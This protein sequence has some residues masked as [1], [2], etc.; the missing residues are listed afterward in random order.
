MINS[1]IKIRNLL[2]NQI[3]AFLR[4]DNP[5]FL[6]FLSEYFK[7]TE[8]QGGP[9]D[10]LNNIDQYVKLDNISE[11][12][13]NTT[14]SNSI[15]IF[16]NEVVV[17]STEG[18]PNNYGLIQ[19]NN[20][21]I[22]YGEKT[23][24]TFLN[25][26]RGFSGITSY[27]GL[28]SDS[29]IFSET[30]S[31]EHSVG[32][33]V[34]NLGN[35]FLRELYKKFKS[36]YAP[37]FD[38]INLYGDVNEKILVSKLKDFYASKGSSP[39][40]KILFKALYGQE[41]DII[42]P[43]D[44]VIQASDADYRITRDLV[45]EAISG[46]PQNLVNL[47]LFQDQTDYINEASG[48][49]TK[50]EKIYRNDIEYYQIS[51]DY[52]P[53]LE[54]SRFT[55][56]PKTKLISKSSDGDT[57]FLVD[58][59]LGFPSYGTLVCTISGTEYY[60]DYTSKSS[61]Q[62]FGCSD[63]FDL[64]VGSYLTTK[65]F[66]YANG[67]DGLVKIR[68]TGVLTELDYPEDAHSYSVDDQIDI[69]SMG[70]D[71]IGAKY[72]NWIFNITPSYE[73]VSLFQLTNKIN[74][75]ARFRA[76][77]RDQNIF[78]LGDIGVLKSNSG[79]EYDF[80]VISISDLNNFD[81]NLTSD[82]DLNAKYT[83][84]RGVTLTNCINYP[85]VNINSTDVQ[86]VYVDKSN[87]NSSQIADD[88]YVVS[89]SLPN[90]LNTPLDIEDFSFIFSGEFDGE[91]LNVGENPF[92]SGD[93]VYYESGGS[94][95]SLNIPDGL[96]FIK[97]E[98]ANI[99]KLATS[100][101]NIT[102]SS[103]ISVFGDVTNNKFQLFKFYNKSLKS[104]DLIRK[105]QSPINSKE[106][107]ETKPGSVGILVNGVELLNYKSND[108]IFYGKINNI[109]I[110]SPG[111]DYDVINPPYL[112]IEDPIGY[113][114]TGVVHVKGSLSKIELINKGFDYIDEP[115]VSIF[116]GN[117]TGAKAK[118]N[119]SA[120]SQTIN[121]SSGEEYTQ[122]NLTNN[123]IGF[124]TYHKFREYEKVIYLTFGQTAIGGLVDKSVYYTEI[125][126]GN[127][128]KLYNNFENA[129]AGINT[130]NFT[131]YGEGS[132]QFKS[133]NKKQIISSIEVLSSGEGY[134]NKKLFFDPKNVNIYS[135]SLNIEN[136]QYQDKEIVI[137]TSSSSLIS[138][139]SS[140]SQYYVKV[141]DKNNIR[142]SSVGIGTT[143]SQDYFYNNKE[144]VSF[145]DQGT[146][147]HELNYLPIVVKVE[148][149]IGITTLSGQDFSAKFQ[150]IFTGNISGVSLSNKG[151]EY[152]NDDIVNYNREP[153]VTLIN[154]SDA[155]V[156]P[157][158]SSTGS[159]I[160]VVINSSGKYYNSP[161]EFTIYGD[162]S[163]CILTGIVSN[164]YLVD[165]K[166]VSGGSGYI[167]NNTR[168][169]VTSRGS[170]VKFNTNITP[171]TINLVERLFDIS[172]ISLD[173]GILTNSINPNYELQ[174]CH[175]YAPRQLRQ[176]LLSYSLGIDGTP[177][178]RPDLE[179]DDLP[180]KYH[181]PIIGWAYDGN[182]I[183]GPY[184]Y[185]NGEGGTVRRMVSGYIIRLNPERP[186]NYNSGIFIEDYVFVG[187]GDLDVHNGRT[188]KTPEFPNGTYAYFM[189]LQGNK[190]STGIF[191]GLLKP[192]FPYIIGQSYKSK[193][194]DFNYDQN[195]NQKTIDLNSTGWLRNT[196][197]YG[198]LSKYTYYDGVVQ[199]N[200]L[201]QKYTLVSEI[202][203]GSVDILDIVSK[204]INYSVNDRLSF[205]NTD[206]S[207]SGAYARITEIFG[208][209]VSEIN[210]VSR[211]IPNVQ[212]FPY[213]S[214]NRFI[215]FSSS[216]HE[217]SNKDIISIQNLNILG[218]RFNSNF[219]VEIPTNILKLSNNIPNVSV[220]GIVTYF[221]VFGNI[222]YPALT[223]NDTLGIGTEQVKVLEIDYNLSKIKV[224]REENFTLG[225]AHSQGA[226]IT[227]IPRKFYFN[228]SG[229]TTSIQYNLNTEIY[230]NPKDTL[231]I[232]SV[233]I[234]TTIVFSNPGVGLTEIFVPY[235]S[236]YLPTHNLI[237]GDQLVYKNNANNSIRVST[238]TSSY[239]LPNN[240]IVYVGKISN[241]LIGISTVKIGIGTTGGFIGITTSNAE[242]LTFSNFGT[243]TDHS[244][245][246]NFDNVIVGDVYKKSADVTT[247]E[248]HGLIVGD[249][250]S[251]NV[252]SG[253][254]T[255]LKVQYNDLNRRLVLDPRTF[256]S[257]D[258]NIVDNTIKISNHGYSSGQKL[259]HVS[260]SPCGGLINGEIYYAIVIDDNTIKLSKVYYNTINS[261]SNL[262]IINIT[263]ASIGTLSQV[264]PRISGI[265][266]STII[267]DLSDPSLSS[268]GYPAFDFNLYT[269][270]NFSNKFYGT[271]KDGSSFNVTKTG[272]IGISNDA[273]LTLILD[274]NTPNLYY[275]LE[276]VQTDDVALSKKELIV[277]DFNIFNNNILDIKDSVYSIKSIVTGVTTNTFSYPLTETPEKS[278]YDDTESIIYYNTNSKTA[279]GPAGKI[280][281][282]SGGRYYNNL[283]SIS[284]VD[285]VGIGSGG[286]FLP[287]SNSIGRI[288][289]Y[290]ISDIGFDYPCDLSLRPSA[291]LPKTFKI[292]PL[293][294][295]ESIRIISP[296]VNYFVAPQLVVID[297]FTGRVNNEVDLRYDIGDTEVTVVRNTTGLYNINPT[298]IPVNNPNGI[299]I[300]SIEYTEA[301]NTVVVGLAITFSSLESFPFSVGDEFI[302]ENTNILPTSELLSDYGYNSSSYNY[303][304]FVAT[305][306]NPDIGG[307]SPT[308]TFNLN[309]Y[310]PPG[311]S[312]G[313]FDSFES[314]GTVTPKNYFPVFLVTLDKGTFI[315]GETVLVDE[316][317][318]GIVQSYDSRNEYLKIR[319]RNKINVND[320]IIGKTSGNKG[321]ISK[322]TEYD[323]TYI[324]GSNSITR[325]GWEKT[326]GY[327]SDN[328]QRIHDNDYYQY[329]SYSVRSPI[330]Y[331]TW[332]PLVSTLNH[333]SGFKKFGELLI[334][335]YDPNTVGLSTDQ[336]LGFNSSIADIISEV[337]LNSVKDFDIAKE[338]SIFVDDSYVSNEL[339]FRLPFLQQYQEFIG[340]R[341]LKVDDISSQFN[342]DNRSFDLY[343]N[344][345][346]IF[347]VSFYGNNGS[348]VN[349]ND[350][351]VDLTNHYFVSG[352]EIQYVPP[353]NDFSNAIG[354][355]L[356]TISGI[357]LTDK[358]PPSV[359][360]IKLDNQKIQLASTPQNSLLFNPIPLDLT[361]VGIGSTHTFKSK[362]QNTRLLISLNGMIQSPVVSTGIT[363]KLSSLVGIGSTTIT[364]SGISSIFGGDLLQIDNEIMKVSGVGVGSTNSI[365]VLR[366]WMGTS[367]ASHI[368]NTLITKLNGNYN[369]V[370]NT[371]SFVEPIWGNEPVG[372]G[373]TAISQN[374]ID[375]AGLTTSTRFSGRVFL[376]SSLNQAFTTSYVKAY[377][378]NYIFDDISQSFNG[379][380]T[381][382]T[383]KQ[384]KIGITSIYQ[385]NAIILVSDIFQGPQRLG[386][387]LTD[388]L[389]D[390]KLTE[391]SGNT[392]LSFTG[393]TPNF[394]IT[395][396]INSTNV[397][398]GG[399]IVSVGS[400]GGL[401]YQ[402][403]VGGGGT[404]IVSAAGTIQS[405]SIGNSGSGY[406]VG[407]QTYIKVG[408]QTF[409]YGIPKITYVG[410]ASAVDG[411][412]TSVNIT[413]PGSGYTSTNPPSVVI[414]YPLSYTD[415]PL[416]YSS[417][418]GSTG[419]GTGATVDIIV[420]Q[421]SSVINFELKNTGYGYGQGDILTV[422]IGGTVGIPTD[423]STFTLYPY[424]EFNVFVDKIYNSKF[425]GWSVGDLLVMDDISKYFNGSRKLFPLSIN[426]DR[427]SFFAK[428]SSGIDLQSNL[429]VFI[430]DVLQIPG[431][432]YTFTGGSILRF[433]DAPRGGSIGIS[434]L[435]DTCK[436]LM[437]TGTQT[438][439][440]KTVSVLETIKIGDDVQLYSDL[441]QT[442]NEDQRL[443]VDVKSA[444]S[445][446]TNNYAGQGV[447]GD[448]LLERPI[449]W[450]RQL[451]DKIIDEK[452]VGKDR[453]Y[454]EPSI[455]PSSYLLSSVGIGSTYIFVNSIRPFF[456][457][458]LEGISNSERNSITIISQ[459]NLI[460]AAAT[461]TISGL[462]TISTI[463]LTN[464]GLGYT[465]APQITIQA[466]QL[467]SNQSATGISSI[468]SVGIVTSIRVGSGGTG[469]FYGPLETLTITQQGSYFP[470]IDL[471]TNIFENARLKT[472]SGEGLNA[473]AN[474]EINPNNFR[475]SNVSITN[476]GFNYKIGDQLFVDVFDNVGLATTTRRSA[477]TDPIIF[478]VSS[479]KSPLVLV[480]P[481]SR[482]IETIENITFS[483]DY[484]LI[485]GVGTTNV[486][487]TTGVV[488]DFYIPQNSFLR[489]KYSIHKSGISTGYY[490]TVT[491]SSVGYG[492]TSLKSNNSI[493]G[494]GVSFLDNVY[495]VTST[496]QI[497]KSIP[498]VGITTVIR[499]VTKVSRYNGL[500]GIATTSY[501]GEYSWGKIDTPIR[502]NPVAFS[503]TTSSYSGITTNPI[504]RR[505]SA[506]KYSGYYV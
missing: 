326:T 64:P 217:L 357:G 277:D 55:I 141:I 426:G 12:V 440:V 114:A 66:A 271:F 56:H 370:D 35:L 145:T 140:T 316:N 26:S 21:I 239:S 252:F 41:I 292:E 100:R 285:G 400:T 401:R 499:V 62:F 98:D 168:I 44:Y 8:V 210:Y 284:R 49:I 46:D 480:Q 181:S 133:F 48:T 238:A 501:Y 161:P 460:S 20:E 191:R 51:L 443:V 342:N 298:I 286:L 498:S 36:Q 365:G 233:G 101:A 355:A 478:T 61:T 302:I 74:G 461:C 378:T 475:V 226:T 483:G 166:I 264:N 38:N 250:V 361:S 232:G 1:K 311:I 449:T 392:T 188:C 211:K 372:Y 157:V 53:D 85:D 222:S 119:L 389:G 371:V 253:I 312:P 128:I 196:H 385:G 407:V 112:H 75:A 352:E 255:S 379:I 476:G 16:D 14:L 81:I 494:V 19:I 448:E 5:E 228:V 435:G 353:N 106:A 338:K 495:E 184:G 418:S 384:N 321:I 37:G 96:Y 221:Q 237:T 90:Y 240:T 479:I 259:I 505:T 130:I 288:S 60:F 148:G 137:Y 273:K 155:T 424:E 439:D 287:D 33:D 409:S 431:E 190:E 320:L 339:I 405:I 487:V 272:T 485:V 178:Y 54:V 77:T 340:N 185:S 307:F 93:A 224:S 201:Q 404:A 376:R 179:N 327:L 434:T 386:N 57:Y 266:Y 403:L 129:F 248:D 388:I 241:D 39:S 47:S 331:D 489:S 234:G 350:N 126:D 414:D 309:G 368:A 169:V 310:L 275:N 199:P 162:G 295:F 374:D 156:T 59:T 391:S 69:I 256:E 464:S 263:S 261:I 158:V 397:P 227:E 281:I 105:I 17:E 216:P 383:L 442:L 380:T 31:E 348:Y 387:S 76:I 293:S 408:I 354:I 450:Y 229:Y 457:D 262:D 150:P 160:D 430:N 86:N 318:T 399:I 502:I 337:D 251:V 243:G 410:Y 144:Y 131:S 10:I 454:Y 116:G 421:G 332:S 306:I 268:N 359:Y 323:S 136:H 257:L 80:I 89:T 202:T 364:V 334:D 24:T 373:T 32:S 358:L 242:L 99:I 182:P 134:S 274:E 300:S 351:S 470:K 297:G 3:P 219:T 206:T 432:A 452:E 245:V 170:G 165:V 236:L 34:Y 142:L 468:N 491:N 109:S 92:Y 235:Q 301:T 72:N 204:G 139:L 231:G 104:Q 415:I 223:V 319:T 23:E 25:C 294:K 194:I 381:Q 174:Y 456:D 152:G 314:F 159:I 412:L 71:K 341:A 176:K 344:N 463:T 482:K 290:T 420:G 419:I 493:L 173:D 291:S 102:T 43:R 11:I 183:Y 269:D 465:V 330:E 366:S 30:N 124:S 375:Y 280:L 289:D 246:T 225:V 58:S 267:F 283:P 324:V 9:I 2:Q 492:I 111:N 467:N 349:L 84:T 393:T 215:G 484:G 13:Y 88:A 477:L 303:K 115:K 462:G 503:T 15:A 205:N 496:S 70:S 218:S 396:D 121:F 471:T 132:Q 18:F 437:Y 504:I 40:F 343:S 167:S 180:S 186:Q 73:V 187:N 171:W 247:L 425:S 213:S 94:G 270:Y 6:E 97:K 113:G 451:V 91:D 122:V 346:P 189:T 427:I 474:I 103:F 382:F 29:L 192:S 68:V 506:L 172:G 406:R 458:P 481:P 164:G 345:Y 118:C 163:G 441:D 335:S 390:Y 175:A 258:V 333:T 402:P 28:N 135:N 369:I 445:I 177:I 436:I 429:L 67:P 488:F 193:P 455:Y 394:N 153:L 276:P 63:V 108:A 65:D 52:N 305:D 110:A 87:Y 336:N 497:Q 125:I 278:S 45:V 367:E 395:K 416:I 120:I 127:T 214:T 254:Q 490:F 356:T 195:S 398:K 198:F 50:V 78:S 438:I 453:A 413:N 149:P 209:P 328:L 7:S 469:Y 459:E 282:E 208:K 22:L 317:T 308:I 363:S 220:T 154:G 313:V 486:G 79:E 325:K 433:S 138:G 360:V 146:G 151:N 279:L 203:N 428:R 329:F 42:R 299:R 411:K 123:T 197:P 296:G 244:F 95:N 83:I 377:D 207:G 147:V 362:N 4:E 315:K 423:K 27:R 347:S 117:G 500:V 212:L 230:F 473:T 447:T 444:D 200:K 446:L 466:P 260:S 422:A 472:K 265:K 322:I 143:I 249:T 304:L 107:S 417:K 82:V